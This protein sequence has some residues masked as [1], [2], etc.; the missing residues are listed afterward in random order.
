MGI[1]D[2]SYGDRGDYYCRQL[3]L[4]RK[5]THTKGTLISRYRVGYA[6]RNAL[7][8][9]LVVFDIPRNITH[10]KI[11]RYSPGKETDKGIEYSEP[12]S[13]EA[14]MHGTASIRLRTTKPCFSLALL[15]LISHH[16]L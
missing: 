11:G 8:Q 10:A 13:S 14:F 15:L 5:R 16:P 3:N 12:S 9:H 1:P 7:V 4:G 6:A 2:M